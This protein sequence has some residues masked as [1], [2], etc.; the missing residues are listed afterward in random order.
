MTNLVIGDVS[1]AAAS[2]FFTLRF[3]FNA[4]C[5]F[6][7]V[8]GAADG[9]AA[10]RIAQLENGVGSATDLRSL[11]WALLQRHHAGLSLQGVGDLINAD[12]VGWSDAMRQTMNA[13]QPD[14][15][16]SAE[17]R[18]AAMRLT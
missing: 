4:L 11:I 15:A 3:D 6:E 16:A 17:K 18:R 1:F 13:A 2:G 5:A 9:P 14:Y 8:A 12:P 7:S 10:L